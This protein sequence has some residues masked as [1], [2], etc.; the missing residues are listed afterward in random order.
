MSNCM[1]CS[2]AAM[3]LVAFGVQGQ[4]PARESQPETKMTLTGCLRETKSASA[5]RD[6]KRI[7]YTLEVA[8]RD[9]KDRSK[10]TY[11]LSSTESVSLAK[12]VGHRVEIEGELLQPPGLP[13]AAQPKPLPGDAQGTFRVS[14]LKMISAKCH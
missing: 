8:E 1:V 2:A 10:T 7:V 3:L 4:Q 14:R 9:A 13:P 6:D 12:H 5:Q 11:Q